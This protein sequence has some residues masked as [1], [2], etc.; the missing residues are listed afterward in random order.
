MYIYIYTIILY[1]QTSV[2]SFPRLISVAQVN[3][4]RTTDVTRVLKAPGAELCLNTCG[5]VNQK[6]TF[7]SHQ[8]CPACSMNKFRAY[9]SIYPYY[10]CLYIYL[11]IYICI[12]YI[13]T[14]S[15][16]VN[17]VLYLIIIDENNVSSRLS[18]QWLYG[19]LCTLAHDVQLRLHH[20]TKCMSCH[21][22]L[23]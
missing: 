5:V 7:C 3:E 13:L 10:P 20:V 19:N 2:L 4:Y 21:K 18:P 6:K 1:P 15:A 12:Y 9:I 8:C 14:L 23:R 17:N 11:Y 22:A 16:N